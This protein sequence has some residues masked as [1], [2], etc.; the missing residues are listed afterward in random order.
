[1]TLSAS[2]YIER[3]ADHELFSELMARRYCYVL[4][5]RQMGKSS[6]AVRTIAKLRANHVRCVSLDLTRI[7]GQ[8]TTPDQWYA[9]LCRE[10]G[11]AMGVEREVP[12]FWQERQAVS[13]MQRFFEFLRDV[14]LPA[15][16]DPIVIFIDETDALLSLPFSADEMLAGIRE[17]YNRRAHDPEYERLAFCLL[18]VAIPTDLIRD[19]R[20]TPFNIGTRIELHDFTLR[21]LGKFAEALGI[22]GARL[23]QRVHYWTNG[24]PYLTQTLCQAISKDPEIRTAKDVDSL[25]KAQFLSPNSRQTNS[26]LA[27][28]ASRALHAGDLEPWPDRFRADLLSAYGAA[29]Q[30]KRVP[31]DDSNRVI[32]LLKLS[33]LTRSD[34]ETIRVRNRI[35]RRVFDREWVRENMPDQELRRQ[36]RAFAL[37]ALRSGIVGLA[38]TLVVAIMAIR[39]ANL[40]RTAQEAAKVARKAQAESEKFSYRA[41]VLTLANAN[42][43]FAKGEYDKALSV[44]AELEDQPQTGWE[45]SYTAKRFHRVG[46]FIKAHNGRIL[47]MDFLPDGRLFSIAIDGFLALW[48]ASTGK[49]TRIYQMPKAS[50]LGAAYP[51]GKDL[52]LLDYEGNVYRFE[53]ATGQIRWQSHVGTAKPNSISVSPDGKYV[54]AVADTQLPSYVCSAATGQVVKSIPPGKGTV[55]CAAWSPTGDRLVLSYDRENRRQ[56]TVMLDLAGWRQRWR[57]QWDGETVL[58]LRFSPDGRR[59]IGTH[60]LGSEAEIDQDTGVEGPRHEIHGNWPYGISAL[61]DHR[62]WVTS[63]LDGYLRFWSDDFKRKVGERRFSEP[64]WRSAVD[65]Q[66]RLAATATATGEIHIWQIPSDRDD[67][68]AY[69][70][71]WH[72]FP[73]RPI[74]SFAL[75]PDRQRVVVSL[76]GNAPKGGASL[77]C[78]RISDGK[79]VW[80]KDV[81]STVDRISFSPDGRLFAANFGG[82]KQV[83]LVETLTGALLCRLPGLSAAFSPDGETLAIGSAG[84]NG[85]QQGWVSTVRTRNWERIASISALYY[86]VISLDYSPDGSQLAIGGGDLRV[87]VVE[88]TG[89]HTKLLLRGH[90]NLSRCVRFD[91]SGTKLFSTGDDGT[92]RIWDARS[93]IPEAI[94]LN[95][96][97][98]GPCVDFLFLDPLHRL[99]SPRVALRRKHELQVWD[100]Q[101]AHLLMSLPAKDPQIFGGIALAPNGD[102]FA[103][104]GSNLVRLER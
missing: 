86:D 18:G 32:A 69:G 71:V 67:P 10:V 17:A 11:R 27:D 7:G 50:M 6:L 74:F 42:E 23:I 52:A 47:S 101:A 60:A 26:T 88:P 41:Y 84:P 93:G 59:L 21:E 8:N 78:L 44:L 98:G 80:E 82:E 94:M 57:R 25:V 14:L 45:L 24:H 5:A 104:E 103:A 68:Q 100:V 65:P 90:S 2:S 51:D 83:S 28:V 61:P 34:G 66:G 77:V 63:G 16:T 40:A 62:G 30:G 19:S 48:D 38:F 96:A 79:T 43:S 72:A 53:L 64:V 55:Q 33:G 12:R 91:P 31:D 29:W 97:V 9:G 35:Y 1:M 70:P 89:L 58:A 13:P 102:L 85:Y 92:L 73:G 54:L 22:N 20:T 3:V 49:A 75:T 15:T 95:S 4:D 76:G 46:R 81:P 37:G 36:R 99:D 56:E 39:N 87:R